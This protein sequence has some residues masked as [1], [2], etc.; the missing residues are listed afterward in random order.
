MINYR[1]IDPPASE[2]ERATV[3]RIAR[4]GESGKLAQDPFRDEEG[5]V[6]VEIVPQNDT[7]TTAYRVH[8]EKPYLIEFA[9]SRGTWKD[10]RKYKT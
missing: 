10:I 7:W 2:D 9:T 5:C 3:R 6:V 1:R 4:W 8:A